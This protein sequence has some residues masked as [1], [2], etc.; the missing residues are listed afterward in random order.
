MSSILVVDDEPDILEAIADLLSSGGRHKVTL[1]SSAAVAIHL[2]ED[3]TFDLLITDGHMPQSSG[4]ELLQAWKSKHPKLPA[5]MMSG[6][7]LMRGMGVLK[8]ADAV[9]AKPFSA[10]DLHGLVE[11]AIA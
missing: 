10:A 2:L 5:V 3:R 9:L 11:R 6:S 7:A 4:L 8:G 1:A